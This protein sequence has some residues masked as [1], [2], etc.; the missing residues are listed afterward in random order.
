VVKAILLRLGVDKVENTQHLISDALYRHTLG[1]PL[2]LGVPQW[3]RTFKSK[4]SLGLP[5]EET[6][7]VQQP[8]A[9]KTFVATA[10]SPSP[11]QGRKPR[12]AVAF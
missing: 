12:R 5:M 10:P 9:Q 11:A 1:E 2:A 6:K 7:A 8:E 3:W 4:Y